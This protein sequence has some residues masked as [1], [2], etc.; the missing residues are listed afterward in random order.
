VDYVVKVGNEELNPGIDVEDVRFFSVAE[1]PD[2]YVELSSN[3]IKQIH[4]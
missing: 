4:K 3:I 2:Y 1:L